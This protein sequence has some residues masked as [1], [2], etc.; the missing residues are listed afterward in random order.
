MAKC[1][2]SCW[3]D[4]CCWFFGLFT[5][6]FGGISIFFGV[7]ALMYWNNPDLIDEFAIPIWVGV[8]LV[9]I[10]GLLM[11]NN[12]CK[13]WE[14]INKEYLEELE[15]KLMPEEEKPTTKRA[16]SFSRLF[17]SMSKLSLRGDGKNKAPQQSERQ[18]FDRLDVLRKEKESSSR[19]G[20]PSPSK[21]RRDKIRQQAKYELLNEQEDQKLHLSPSWYSDL[22]C[23]TDEDMNK[24][25]DKMRNKRLKATPD[26]VN[27]ERNG[28]GSEQLGSEYHSPDECTSEK[29]AIDKRRGSKVNRRHRDTSGNVDEFEMLVIEQD[30]KPDH[31]TPTSRR[32]RQKR[33]HG[34]NSDQGERLGDDEIVLKSSGLRRKDMR[35]EYRR[36]FSE[37]CRDTGSISN[38]GDESTTEKRL[39]NKRHLSLDPNANAYHAAGNFLEVPRARGRRKKRAGSDLEMKLEEMY[40]QDSRSLPGTP[41]GRRRASRQQTDIPLYTKSLPGTPEARRRVSNALDYHDHVDSTTLNFYQKS[42]RFGGVKQKSPSQRSVNSMAE[43]QKRSLDKFMI[44]AFM[45]QQDSATEPDYFTTK[46][47]DRKQRRSRHRS[48]P[49]PMSAKTGSSRERSIPDI[50]ISQE[51]IGSHLNPDQNMAES[52]HFASPNAYNEMAVRPKGSPRTGCMPVRSTSPKRS[53][54]Q[55]PIQGRRSTEPALRG[56]ESLK[57]YRD[58]FEADGYS[59]EALE[60]DIYDHMVRER[61]RKFKGNITEPKVIFPTRKRHRTCPTAS[62]ATRRRY[63]DEIQRSPFFGLQEAGDDLDNVYANSFAPRKQSLPPYLNSDR[64]QRRTPGKHRKPSIPYLESYSSESEGEEVTSLLGSRIALNFRGG[65]SS[66]TVSPSDSLGSLGRNPATPP[67]SKMA[68]RNKKAKHHGRN[69]D[70]GLSMSEPT[71]KKKAWSPKLVSDMYETSGQEN[72]ATES[73]TFPPTTWETEPSP[74]KKNNDFSNNVYS[75]EGEIRLLYHSNNEDAAYVKNNDG[76]VG[77]SRAHVLLN[78]DKEGVMVVMVKRRDT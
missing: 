10:G 75:D 57:S 78:D 48:Q 1:C 42:S 68:A 46:S 36:S 61:M 60:V 20:S 17:K 67:E 30:T 3:Y 38:I 54:R 74:G 39:Q 12:K 23:L 13:R 58:S 76:K 22:N 55:S 21:S 70:G 5:S 64:R 26:C 73:E 34:A 28:M 2:A 33:K 32:S 37:G 14:D 19:Q 9:C 27:D 16:E 66:R 8:F 63:M 29:Q 35:P 69:V 15:M 71:R 25:Q 24:S 45:E 6:I 65:K 72:S 53:P 59:S 31:S 51:G 4:R 50:V 40:R 56:L 11:A 77:N 44:P 18:I 52:Q 49:L 62:P 47:L 41:E 43:Y 7:G